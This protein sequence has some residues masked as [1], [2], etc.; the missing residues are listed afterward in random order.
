MQLTLR[1]SLMNGLL[2]EGD[3]VCVAESNVEEYM[4]NNAIARRPSDPETRR[5]AE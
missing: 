4:M 3:V 1:K 5:Y 2:Q